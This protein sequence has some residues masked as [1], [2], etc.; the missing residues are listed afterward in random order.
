M[1]REPPTVLDTSA[2]VAAALAAF[3]AFDLAAPHIGH[4][5]GAVVEVAG[6]GL[7][8]IPLATLVPR[9][10][11]RSVSVGAWMLPAT[12]MAVAATA[13][14]IL[15]GHPTGTPAT[16]TKLCAASLLGLALGSLLE[17]GAEIVGVALLIA[18]VDIYS[19]EAGPTRVIVEHHA[20]VLNDFTLA[21]H[22]IG[23]AGVAQIGA[24]DFLFLAVFLSA[25]HRFD[26]RVDAGWLA[27]TASFGITVL[28][29]YLFDRD[30]PALPLLSL[31]F[32][33][34]NA[35]PLRARMRGRNGSPE[36]E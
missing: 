35:A 5:L 7:I 11:L 21:L 12:A 4:D 34:V 13:G 6:L 36:R 16:L 25:A 33:L 23:S 19:V 24:S 14:L 8:S 18:A 27:M 32:L 30:L 1:V 2:R 15:A 17:S 20:G 26:L 29:S 9:T 10:M 28:V 3:A 22:P 31:S